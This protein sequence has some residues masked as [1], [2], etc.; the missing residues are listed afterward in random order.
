MAD[1]DVEQTAPGATEAYAWGRNHLGQLGVGSNVDS[2]NHAVVA[3]L[4]GLEDPIILLAS[5][6]NHSLA[7]SAKALLPPRPGRATFALPF[8]NRTA[9]TTCYNLRLQLRRALRPS[10]NQHRVVRYPPTLI[11]SLQGVAITKASTSKHS[12]LVSAT[13]QLWA[14]GWNCDGQLGLGS[15]EDSSV[16]APVPGIPPVAQ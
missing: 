8:C 13:G 16:P 15:V 4:S 12:L 5:R 14:F 6:D 3:G 1:M 10:H 7:V 11:C 2:S 9:P